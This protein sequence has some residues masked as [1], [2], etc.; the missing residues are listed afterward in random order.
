MVLVVGN[1]VNFGLFIFGI[2]DVHCN[3]VNIVFA[4]EVVFKVKFSWCEQRVVGTVRKN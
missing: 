1:I 2:K 4:K 3:K